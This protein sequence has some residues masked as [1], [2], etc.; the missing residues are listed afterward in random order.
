MP[1]DAA[2]LDSPVPAADERVESTLRRIKAGELIQ[3]MADVFPAYHEALRQTLYIA[4]QSEVTVLT[5]AYTA[6]DTAPDIGAKIAISAT[7]QDEIGHA[8]LAHRTRWMPHAPR[9]F[10]RQALLLTLSL[11][12]AQGDERVV[13]QLITMLR[14]KGAQRAS[15]P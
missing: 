4:A 9:Q 5:W 7:I 15:Q 2:V 14:Q 12:P 6:Y 13:F 11:V 1:T 8:Q 3:D 10:L